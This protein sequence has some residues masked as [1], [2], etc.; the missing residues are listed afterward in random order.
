MQAWEEWL[1]EAGKLRGLGCLTVHH[2][3]YVVFASDLFIALASGM[4]IQVGVSLSAHEGL[5]EHVC[6]V[7][8]FPLFFKDDCKM[9]A[10]QVC[11]HVWGHAGVC[12]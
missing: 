10:A 8:F 12:G 3:P 9:G 4:T 6:A 11:W 1:Q 5:S 7:Q 2:V